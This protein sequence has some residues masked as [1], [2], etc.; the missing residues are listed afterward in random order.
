MKNLSNEKIQLKNLESNLGQGWLRWKS[1]R[2]IDL[3][4]YAQNTEKCRN[5]GDPKAFLLLIFPS[6]LLLACMWYFMSQARS[7]VSLLLG[8][9]Q[10]SWPMPLSMI[11][12]C[13]RIELVLLQ[14][15]WQSALPGNIFNH[16]KWNINCPVLKNCNPHFWLK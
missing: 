3:G 2:N 1:T 12:T 14:R 15:I 8:Y 13:G 9:S 4:R 16:V 7:P 6:Y 10:D 5:Y 11:D